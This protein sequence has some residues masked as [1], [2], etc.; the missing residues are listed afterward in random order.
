M[1]RI[2]LITGSYVNTFI[3]ERSADTHKGQCGRVLV[4]AGSKGMAGAAVLAAG[5]ALRSGA[6]L[7]QAAVPDELFTILQTAVPQATCIS[8]SDDFS[9]RS[10]EIYD[11]AAV[12][13]GLG[14]DEQKYYTIKK[15]LKEY[16]GTVVLDADGI[17]NMCRFDRDLESLRK[18][19]APL[20]L[21][22]HPGEGDRLLDAIGAKELRCSS[23]EEAVRYICEKTGAVV[24]LKGS[25]TLVAAPGEQTYINTTGNPGMATGGSGDVLTGVIAAIAASGVPAADSARAGAFIHGMAGDIAADRL[26]QW[27]TTSLDI[28]MA[29]PAA[30]RKITGK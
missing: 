29:L 26:G 5:A 7:V 28:Q 14:V 1:E 16:E 27:G 30:F 19:Q 21:T 13:P 8:T 22:P 10:L 3:R 23:R 25:G 11:A 20:I 15:I 24:L 17:N 2:C 4:L 12:G 9:H 18:R 6:G